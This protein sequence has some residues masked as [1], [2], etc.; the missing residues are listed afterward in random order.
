[1]NFKLICFLLIVLPLFA[2]AA[3]NLCSDNTTAL[4]CSKKKP[5]YCGEDFVLLENASVCGC[6]SGYLIDW[7]ACIKGPAAKY[8]FTVWTNAFGS[9]AIVGW[10]NLPSYADRIRPR[11]SYGKNSSY[12]KIIEM[13]LDGVFRSVLEGLDFNKTYHYRIEWCHNLNNKCYYSADKNFTTRLKTVF[14]PVSY[15]IKPKENLVVV[16]WTTEKPSFG[17]LQYWLPGER[18]IASTFSEADASV[19]ANHSFTLS[20]LKANSTYYFSLWARYSGYEEDWEYSQDY[21]FTFVSAD[22]PVDVEYCVLGER[23]CWAGLEFVCEKKPVARLYYQFAPTGSECGKPQEEVVVQLPS[24]TP[25]P[26]TS[27]SPSPKATSIAKIP[28]SSPSPSPQAVQPGFEMKLDNNTILIIGVV[29]V[30]LGLGAIMF[31]PR[32]D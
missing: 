10:S 32:R 15:E 2:S 27:P 31:M 16:S 25:S 30:L 26:S 13:K 9:K 3:S 24:P 1:V 14:A 6:A 17:R 19:Q 29:F 12:G 18:I 23:A 20:G 28:T 11:V 4:N 5:Y 21:N 7:D 22:S 8:N